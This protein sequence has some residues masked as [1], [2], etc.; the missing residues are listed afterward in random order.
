[1]VKLL[2]K[3]EGNF[4]KFYLKKFCHFQW[5]NFPQTQWCKGDEERC[6]QTEKLVDLDSLV[7]PADAEVRA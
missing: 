6:S 2:D 1:L 4:L 3:E 7:D 5:A